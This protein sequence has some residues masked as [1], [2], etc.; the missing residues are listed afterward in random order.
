MPDKIILTRS[1]L[2]LIIITLAIAPYCL[3]VVSVRAT[4]KR[5]FDLHPEEQLFVFSAKKGA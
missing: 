1:Q 3:N 2:H 5:F 4:L